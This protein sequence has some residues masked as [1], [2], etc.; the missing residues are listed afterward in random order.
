MFC[1]IWPLTVTRASFTGRPSAVTTEPESVAVPIGIRR[2]VGGGG[3][4]VESRI[5][6]G[7]GGIAETCAATSAPRQRIHVTNTD[8]DDRTTRIEPPGA[9][10]DGAPSV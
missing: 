8:N 1:G 5:W 7:G 2:S 6:G 3:G 4:A 9:N 10:F